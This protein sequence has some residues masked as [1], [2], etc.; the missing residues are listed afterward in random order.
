MLKNEKANERN[1][2][3]NLNNE[4][5]TATNVECEVAMYESV[6][7]ETTTN[8]LN[9]NQ[10]HQNGEGAAKKGHQEHHEELNISIASSS[11]S[12]SNSL[13]SHSKLK[14]STHSI[15]LN[16]THPVPVMAYSVNSRQKKINSDESSSVD[17]RR[18]IEL[19]AFTVPNRISNR[20]IIRIT[21]FV[22]AIK[23]WYFNKRCCR[24]EQ[25]ASETR[26][27]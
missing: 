19:S 25:I 17:G 13:D 16:Q 9:S 18:N 14:L 6:N 20:L 26:R 24:K 15:N 11:S 2:S 7:V 12:S 8:D 21:Y 27:R 10:N 1:E 23:F 4:S 5:K 3:S 22:Y